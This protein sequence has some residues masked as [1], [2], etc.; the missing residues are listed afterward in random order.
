MAPNLKIENID[1][2]TC[3][4]VRTLAPVKGLGTALRLGTIIA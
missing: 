3:G 4:Y 2:Y 1:C